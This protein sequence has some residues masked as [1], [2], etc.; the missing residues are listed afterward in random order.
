MA[1]LY[2]IQIT[3]VTLQAI[4]LNG[5]VNQQNY[6]EV[7]REVM[8]DNTAEEPGDVTRVVMTTI[9][10]EE[11]NSITAYI[12]INIIPTNDPAFI[13]DG[14]RT[15]TFNE[16]TR[17][18]LS[19]FNMADT[20]SDTDGD[21]LAWVYITITNDTAGT[22]DMLAADVG[23]TS[24]RINMVSATTLNITGIASFSVYEAV[25][26]TVTFS[27]I[28][29]GLQT[30]TRTINIQTFDGQGPP[31]NQTIE[32]NIDPSNDPPI[33]YFNQV[34]SLLYVYLSK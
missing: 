25:L 16:Q 8:Y 15:L 14:T 21:S 17:M 9:K 19:L 22:Y 4:L 27:N 7:L 5:S 33:C 3:Q 6:A 1:S 28:F 20:I 10:D 13:F 2:G 32:I 29:P 31:G 30:N 11:G 18:P 23:S 24:L 34:V 26:Q 12:T